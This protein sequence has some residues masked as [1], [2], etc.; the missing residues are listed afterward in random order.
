MT[1][2]GQREDRFGD[3]TK[4]RALGTRFYAMS[5]ERNTVIVASNVANVATVVGET[6]AL[7]SDARDIA[8]NGSTQLYILTDLGLQVATLADTPVLGTKHAFNPGAGRWVI[9]SGGYV[10]APAPGGLR[11]IDPALGEVSQSTAY[12]VADIA[13][14]RLTSDGLIYGVD[15]KRAKIHVWR[16]MGAR[17]KYISSFAAYNCRDIVQ[18]LIDETAHILFVQCKHRIVGFNIPSSGAVDDSITVTL[19]QDYG[20]LAEDYTDFVKIGTNKY[21]TGVNADSPLN[22]GSAFLGRTYADWDVT[23]Q[24]MV[25]AFPDMAMFATSDVTPYV[26]EVA[27]PPA[28]GIPEIPVIVPPVIPV[29]PVIPPYVPPIVAVPKPVITSLLTASVT[30][31]T[32]FSYTITATGTGPIYYDTVGAPGWVTSINHT[33][34]VVL[35]MP[36]DPGSFNITITAT[37][38]GGTDTKTLVVTVMASVGNNT[39]VSVNGGV[40]SAVKVPSATGLLLYVVGSFTTVRDASGAYTRNN[41]ACLNVTTGLW[42][43]WNPNA[44]AVVLSIHA[45]TDGVLFLGGSSGAM[46]I[47]GVAAGYLNRV[48]AATGALVSSVA[49]DGVIYAYLSDGSSL[50][51]GGSFTSLGGQT[52]EGAGCLGAGTTVTSWRIQNSSG[53]FLRLIGSAAIGQVYTLRDSGSEVLYTGNAALNGQYPVSLAQ[54]FGYASKSTG[55]VTQA[56]HGIRGF[57]SACGPLQSFAGGLTGG[58]QSDAIVLPGATYLGNSSLANIVGSTAN[59]SINPTL[60]GAYP[61]VTTCLARQDGSLLIGGGGPRYSGSLTATNGDGNKRGLTAITTVGGNASDFTFYTR[62]SPSAQSYNPSASVLVDLAPGVVAVG[63]AIG[64]SGDSNHTYD[65][66]NVGNLLIL[67]TMTGARY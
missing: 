34:G 21:W 59:L 61:Y 65:G 33:T 42:T 18:V 26:G 11:V 15:Q 25:A 51:V 53:E 22:A 14:A 46:T 45:H 20:K 6:A 58:P 36:P 29:I 13:L 66:T 39:L 35:G 9:Y 12:G 63:G 2:A 47:G 30:E 40:Y 48:S 19:R 7:G 27:I 32:V 54:G 4:V 57:A 60:S 28:P 43:S 5:G 67:N 37:N 52:R 10:F 49:C 44:S 17:A 62:M 24:A 55:I 8:S 50:Y 23:N 64:T 3:I 38:A 1:T 56:T 41:A 16:I 31:D